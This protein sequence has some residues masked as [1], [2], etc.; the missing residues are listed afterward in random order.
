MLAGLAALRDMIGYAKNR[1]DVEGTVY[2]VDP[3]RKREPAEYPENQT[4]A[5]V[6]LIRVMKNIQV[7]AGLIEDEAREQLRLLR[8][9]QDADW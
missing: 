6:E 8:L 1:W 4:M 7:Q 3:P 9:H 2:G 5:W